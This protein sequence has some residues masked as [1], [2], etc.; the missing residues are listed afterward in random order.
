MAI[1]SISHGCADSLFNEAPIGA[2][3]V[4]CPLDD[5]VN[6]SDWAQLCRFLGTLGEEQFNR[7]KR[8]LLKGA[9]VIQDLESE[10][11]R[12]KRWDMVPLLSVGPSGLNGDF[13]R[14]IGEEI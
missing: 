2:I 5:G 6:P 14:E 3:G 12:P 4:W 1:Q 9:E 13:Q 7:V 10:D 8:M 11:S